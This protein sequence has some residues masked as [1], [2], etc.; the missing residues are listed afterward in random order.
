VKSLRL[1]LVFTFIIISSMFSSTLTALAAPPY[2]YVIDKGGQR[3]STPLGYSVER[4]LSGDYKHGMFKDPDDLFIDIH[5]NIY[6]VDTGNNR[7]V[8]MDKLGKTLNIYGTKEDK[9]RLMEPKGIFV[10]DDGDMYIADTGNSRIVHISPDG[11]LIE[12]FVAPKSDLIDKDF[13]FA[14]TKLVLDHGGNMYVQ[15]GN[16][17]HGLMVIDGH[18]DFQGYV[19]P[20]KLPFSIKDWILRKYA[21]KAQREALGKIVPPNHRNVTIDFKEGYLYTVIENTRTDEIKRFNFLGINTYPTSHVYGEYSW[22]RGVTTSANIADIAIDSSGTITVVDSNQRKVYQYDQDGNMLIAFGGSGDQTGFFQEPVSVAVDSEG[23]YYI[24]DRSRD[25][26]QVFRANHFASLVHNASKLFNEGRYD[27]ALEPWKQVLEIDSNYNLAHRGVGKALFKQEKW[28]ESMVEFRLGEDMGNYSNAFR[29][30]RHDVLRQQFVWIVLIGA[31]LFAAFYYSIVLIH[32]HSRRVEKSFSSMPSIALTI[33]SP[34]ESFSRI[35]N[36]PRMLPAI[37]VIIGVLAARFFHIYFTSFHYNLDRPEFANLYLESSQILILFLG[38]VI[39]VLLV[40]SIMDGESKLK[41]IFAA[42]AYAM[43]PYIIGTVVQA[44]MSNLLSRDELSIYDM[45]ATATYGWMFL[46]FF[47]KVMVMNDYM[48]GKTLQV[49]IISILTGISL[50]LVG[51]LLFVLSSHV[52][53]F[54]KE[55]FLELY[56][57]GF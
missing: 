11:K 13:P 40:T 9:L 19:A 17:Y 38:W 56:I 3:I 54:F 23:L 47:I 51:I 34:G 12:K 4:V 57:R 36:T 37:L 2:G 6:I 42:S 50:L 46:L 43:I 10:E 41:Q 8:K 32:A 30:Y 5:D 26:V 49:V 22:R 24:L 31:A 7:I 44:L 18:N 14:P 39:S 1:G 55:I 15:S 29:E 27:E 21:T 25:E 33:F 16:D 28:Q 35:Q 20:N 48:V 52:F 45:I 53:N